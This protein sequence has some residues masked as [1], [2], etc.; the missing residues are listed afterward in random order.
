MNINLDRPIRKCF[1]TQYQSKKN[2]IP[3]CISKPKRIFCHVCKEYTECIE[4]ILIKRYNIKAFALLLMCEKCNQLKS[5]SFTDIPREK[6]NLFY[7]NLERN[8]SYLNYVPDDNKNM[9]RIL[10]DIYDI[11]KGR[12]N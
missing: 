3:A 4:P 11:I 5:D 12:F 7:F 6:F 10:D 9:H 1:Y 8:K 2:Y